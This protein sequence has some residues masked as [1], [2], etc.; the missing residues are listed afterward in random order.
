MTDIDLEC[1]GCGRK[2]KYARGIDPDI[3]ETVV[4]IV[5]NE[6]DKCH[7]ASGGFGQ[8]DWYDKSGNLVGPDDLNEASL[9]KALEKIDGFT[10]EA[11]L[12]TTSHP[13]IITG[14]GNKKSRKHD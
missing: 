10:D 11:S 1:S 2:I 9:A 13:F 12:R 3:P 8:E 5:C 4:R 7:A 14:F 6:C